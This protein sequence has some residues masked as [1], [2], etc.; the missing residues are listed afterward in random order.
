M[1]EVE[2]G[3]G[4]QGGPIVEE[5]MTGRERLQQLKARLFPPQT[6]AQRVARAL[7]G[8]RNAVKP[9]R[10]DPAVVRYIAQSDD[11]EGE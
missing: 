7:E 6:Q 2:Q 10:L 5:A 3:T 9:S 11:L 8:L 4:D 1:A